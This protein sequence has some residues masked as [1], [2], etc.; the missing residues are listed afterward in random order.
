MIPR[1]PIMVESALE[2]AVQAVARRRNRL[3]ARP[4]GSLSPFSNRRVVACPSRPTCRSEKGSSP[5]RPLRGRGDL[6]GLELWAPFAGCI[7]YV[8]FARGA[9]R[10]VSRP[11]LRFSALPQRRTAPDD[12][13]S[14]RIAERCAVAFVFF[15]AS[16][17]LSIGRAA[18]VLS[19]L[20]MSSWSSVP[21]HSCVMRSDETAAVYLLFGRR[22]PPERVRYP[23]GG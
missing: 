9:D 3:S 15:I 6:G 4:H 2:P 12:L 5:F 13:P 8:R 17:D 11:A 18:P 16:T 1:D 20:H 22:L 10:R 23:L 14:S 19:A 21:S 7:G